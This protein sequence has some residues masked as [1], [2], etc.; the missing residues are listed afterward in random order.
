MVVSFCRLGCMS[1]LIWRVYELQ[2]FL[3]LLLYNRQRAKE[4]LD[5][6]SFLSP[7]SIQ[8]HATHAR[9][10]KQNKKCTRNATTNAWK[11]RKKKTKVRKRNSRNG[12]KRSLRKK[13]QRYNR[14]YFSRNERKRQPIGMLGWSSQSWLPTQALALC[15]L[16]AFEWKPG[17]RRELVGCV[18]QWLERRSL[19]G[20]LSLASAQSVADVWPLMWV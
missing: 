9:P 15:A 20:E 12:R 10:C 11:L 18:A 8:T 19:T 2:F 6:K 14:F 3:H 1:P 4:E 16:R 17:F 7:V 13:T 5:N